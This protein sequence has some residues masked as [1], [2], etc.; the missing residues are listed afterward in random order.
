M[1]LLHGV[2]CSTE[3]LADGERHSL[4]TCTLL[5]LSYEFCSPKGVPGLSLYATDSRCLFPPRNFKLESFLAH[6]AV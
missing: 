3:G 4:G 2:A 6:C 5:A 1:W